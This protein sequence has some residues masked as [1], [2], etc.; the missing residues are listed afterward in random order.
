MTALDEDARTGLRLAVLD[1]YADH[2]RDLP[3]RR[4]GTSAWAVLVSEVML[5]Q[6][7]VRR[8]EPR[9]REWMAR[10][11]TP[12]DLAEAP[13]AEVL[14]AWDR[15]GYPRRALRLQEAARA[16]TAEH[17]GQVPT[18]E[19]TLRTLPGIGDYT[20][21]AV[22]AFAYR[23]HAVVL[24]T[25]V[26]RVLARAV[27]GEALPPPSPRRSETELAASLLPDDG[28]AAAR[29][30]V[31]V[32]ELG[33]LVCTARSPRCEHC[34][35]ADRCAWLAAGRPA[36]AHAH[37][38]RPQAWHGT[39]R[40]ARGRV[41]AAL[42]DRD[43]LA[44]VDAADLWPDPVQRERILAALVRDGLAEVERDADGVPLAYRLPT[45]GAGRQ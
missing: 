17:G 3:W 13:A 21:A 5:Q 35:L 18:A 2:A 42:R 33:A 23:R 9:W 6:T 29:V 14:R 26:R 15:L 12:A 31:A 40:Q 27:R 45:G 20:A 41:M 8:V 36:D 10:W 44:A 22:T 34:P 7:P 24:D 19:Q 37:R 16:I 39:D 11:P 25:N 1:W 43:E 30:S 4:P 28:A 32:M 38:R